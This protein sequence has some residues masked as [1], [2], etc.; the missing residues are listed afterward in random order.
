VNVHKSTSPSA[1]NTAQSLEP[2][3]KHTTLDE[4]SK[5]DA[6]LQRAKDLVEL[7]YGVKLKYLEEGLD[8]ELQRAREDVMRVHRKLS[9]RNPA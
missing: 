4:K 6:D 1:L 5:S 7:H 3:S 8:A 2:V 9:N